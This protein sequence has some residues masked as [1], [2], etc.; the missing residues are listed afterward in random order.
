M[1]LGYKCDA[2]NIIFPFHTCYSNSFSRPLQ[3]FIQKFLF[4]FMGY[5][6]IK[7]CYIARTFM[8]TKFSGNHLFYLTNTKLWVILVAKRFIFE[9]I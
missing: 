7:F 5:S 1:P 8:S 2:R 9:D 6:Y 4:L 3:L